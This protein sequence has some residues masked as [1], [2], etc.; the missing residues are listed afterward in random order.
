M[1]KPKNAPKAAGTTKGSK[2]SKST[3]ARPIL[4]GSH[5]DTQTPGGRYD[6]TLGALSALIASGALRAQFGQ[7]KRTLE[8]LSLYEWEPSPRVAVRKI[9]RNPSR[10][11]V[12]T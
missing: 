9:W 10:P 7:P 8:A 3:P 2:T 4:T 1:T 5:M 11:R 12:G 6:G